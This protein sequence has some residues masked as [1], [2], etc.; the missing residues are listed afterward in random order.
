MI[1]LRN[2]VYAS[3]LSILNVLNISMVVAPLSSAATTPLSNNNHSSSNEV[4][5]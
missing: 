1:N 4:I 2:T 5:L 3:P